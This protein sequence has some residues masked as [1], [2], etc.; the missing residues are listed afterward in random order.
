MMFLFTGLI[1]EK[2]LSLSSCR[3]SKREKV[4]LLSWFYTE[5]K[6]IK[7]MLKEQCNGVPIYRFI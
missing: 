4:H 7:N 5:R 1:E 3:R 6:G 2:E